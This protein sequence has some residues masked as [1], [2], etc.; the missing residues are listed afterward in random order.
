[1]ALRLE[2]HIVDLRERAEQHEH[3]LMNRRLGVLTVLSAI[4]LPLTLLTGIWGMNFS[5]M[6]E[7]Q[8]PYSY[9]LAL[10]FMLSL[11]LFMIYYFR[12]GGWLD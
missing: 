11:A 10:M 12:R 7:L 6:P 8:E 5:S 2:K 4:F 1:M 3:T 9:P